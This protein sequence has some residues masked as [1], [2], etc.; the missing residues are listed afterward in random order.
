M[1]QPVGRG[2]SALSHSHLRLPPRSQLTSAFSA[3]ASRASFGVSLLAAAVSAFSGAA[4]LEAIG[5]D[6]EPGGSHGPSL[7]TFGLLCVLVSAL[8]G[9]EAALFVQVVTSDCF[10]LLLVAS[11][12]FWLL[13]IDSG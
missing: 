12:C 4:L 11:D 3:A 8:I 6:N 1:A 10:R 13:P 2:A 5:S 7:Y 9:K